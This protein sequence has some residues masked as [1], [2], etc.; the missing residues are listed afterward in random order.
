M[1]ISIGL[2]G[3][4]SFGSAFAKLFKA[5]PAVSRIGLCDFEKSKLEKFANDPF[6][7]DKLSAKDIYTSLDDICKADFDALVIITQPWLH[8][9]QCIKALESGKSVY[10]AVPVIEIPDGDE[11]LDWCGK[12]REAVKKS[13]RHYMLGETTFFHPQTM[14]CRRMAAEGRFGSFVYA[15]GD[16]THDVDAP[17]SLREVMRSRTTGFIGEQFNKIMQPY[18]G[19]NI[20]TSPMFYPTHSVS[21]PL[22]VMNTRAVKVSA[23]G[24]R[25]RTCDPF[26]ANADFS[27][28]TALFQ[29][30]NGASFRV[31]EYRE[32]GMF[33]LDRKD[34]ETFRFVGTAGSF[35]QDVWEENFR[36]PG[37][38]A[39]R[40]IEKK[41]MTP[42]EM[43]DK[44]PAEVEEAFRQVMLDGMTP[45]ERKDKQNAD[46]VPSGHGGSHPYLVHEFCSSVAENRKPEI[47]IDLASHYMAMG[48]AANKSAL[49]DGELVKVVE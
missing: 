3:L 47:D 5:H 9:P 1:G 37:R 15:E 11:I 36:G 8:A 48:V 19:K 46:F 32:C 44:F 41:V 38:D 22:A 6:M 34:T 42:G 25:N 24:F 10:S 33:A 12:L 43:F 45:E 21:G 18:Y 14:F 26:F 35:A 2:V 27:N 23:Y 4:G 30:A 49:K 31:C 17:C 13:G 16:Y 28:V 20:R 7:Q 29:L 39:V 40:P